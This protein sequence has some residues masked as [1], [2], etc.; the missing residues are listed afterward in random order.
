ME[1]RENMWSWRLFLRSQLVLASIPGG[2]SLAADHADTPAL[3][4]LGR[5]DARITDLH[6]FVVGSDLVLALSTNPNIPVGQ[7]SYTFAAD[8]TL[9]IYLDTGADVDREA[10]EFGGNVERPHRISPDVTFTVTFPGGVPTLHAD[11]LRRDRC[12]PHSV[13]LFAGLRDD[14]FI[15]APRQGRNVASVV[16]QVPLEA[17]RRHHKPRLLIWATSDVPSV[18]GPLV[19]HAGRA[20]RS[21]NLPNDAMNVMPP[22]AHYTILGLV[23]DVMIFD[24]SRPA[25]FPNGRALEDDVV[26]MLPDAALQANDG[27]FPTGNDKPFLSSFPYLAEPW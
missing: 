24:T 14:P 25:V 27:P 3:V 26:D 12:G 15:R 21:Q 20:L 9:K 13:Q 23:P 16:V 4:T 1:V 18:N 10:N 7:T 22:S 19:E 11:G 5:H 2:V 17:V 8:L 6:A